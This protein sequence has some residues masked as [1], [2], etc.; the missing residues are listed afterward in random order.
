MQLTG[1]QGLFPPRAGQQTR[2][3]QRRR[4]SQ[5]DRGTP[6]AQLEESYERRGNYGQVYSND[7]STMRF[8]CQQP[9]FAGRNLY[10]F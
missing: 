1:V 3:E 9:A 2:D 6:R 8:G 5:F 10:Q 4:R 7:R